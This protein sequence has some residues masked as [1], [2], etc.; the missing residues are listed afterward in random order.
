MTTFTAAIR[1]YLR[2][3]GRL[4][5]ESTDLPIEYKAQY[6]AMLQ[7][8]WNFGAEVLMTGHVSVTI[9]DRKHEQDNAMRVVNNGPDVQRALC[10][11]LDELFPRDV[12]SA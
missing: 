10:D 12:T 8:D 7:R 3:D 2:P 9:E 11:M 5:E 6:E 4:R 1:Q